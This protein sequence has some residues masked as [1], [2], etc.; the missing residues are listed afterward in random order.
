MN[1]LALQLKRIGDLALTTPALLAIKT[2]GA[3]VTLVVAAGTEALLPA[4]V[5]FCVDEAL[6]YRPEG[7][8][9]ALWKRLV[10]GG[11]D[12]CVDFT[13]RDRSALMTLLSH[14]PRR[15]IARPALRKGVWRRLVYNTLVD[16]SVR[17]RHT[18]DHYLDHLG[19]L[20]LAAS[21]AGD[22]LAHAALQLPPENAARAGEL[23]GA[24]GIGENE[25]FVV[26]HPGSARAEKYWVPERWAEVIRF[27]GRERNLRCV[28]TGGSG[29]KFEQEHLAQI[30]AALEADA[31]LCVD[32][33]GRLDLLTL[34]ALLARTALSVSVDSGPMH[35]A[36][37]FRRPQIAL[38]GP[39]N[40]FH[41]RP[42]HPDAFVLHSGHGDLPLREFNEDS[43]GGPTDAISTQAVI[44]AIKQV[45]L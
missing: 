44:D 42:R 27:V 10:C 23:L 17:S 37:A 25:S 26:V 22:N 33:A 5:G 32:F 14:A 34:T 1:V 2:G 11:F 21:Q 3:H 41:W 24:A 4:L 43:P 12:A 30:R 13:G 20:P 18:V 16:S 35:L 39:T 7:G 28:L 40:P 19:A 45:P 36:A 38:F 6:V 29:D 15:I 8:N 9:F 31:D